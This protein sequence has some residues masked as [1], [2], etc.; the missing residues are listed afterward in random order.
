MWVGLT[1]RC[2]FQV[3]HIL[4]SYHILTVNLDQQG[5]SR[6]PTNNLVPGNHLS[7]RAAEESGERI[8]KDFPGVDE[9]SLET[10][11]DLYSG[12]EL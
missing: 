7:L 6:H 3:G 12:E 4:F 9:M 1:R 11:E 5:I 2:P 10:W 8:L